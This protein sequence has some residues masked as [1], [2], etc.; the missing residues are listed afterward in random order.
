MKGKFGMFKFTFWFSKI[1]VIDVTCR[2]CVQYLN[3]CAF[4]YLSRWKKSDYFGSSFIFPSLLMCFFFRSFVRY[5]GERKAASSRPRYD[6][7]QT[8]K[9]LAKDSL[10]LSYEK[11]EFPARNQF[12]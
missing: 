3:N 11:H 12:H 9:F 4:D 7:S 5:L 6:G 10:I 8:T 1:G 2:I